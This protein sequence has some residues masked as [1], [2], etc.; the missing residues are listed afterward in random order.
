MG[1]AK[2]CVT[3]GY[4]FHDP[5]RMFG[6]ESPSG[7]VGLRRPEAVPCK[8]EAAGLPRDRCPEPQAGETGGGVE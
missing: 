8:G 1:D 7:L 5:Q 4:R 6:S 2:I 3:V